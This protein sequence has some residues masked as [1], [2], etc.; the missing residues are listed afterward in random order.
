MKW[1][2]EGLV[3]TETFLPF[4]DS[5]KA[6][7]I[8]LGK[9]GY[10]I[11]SIEF[12]PYPSTGIET[13]AFA[14][15]LRK[16]RESIGSVSL[17]DAIYLEQISTLLPTYSLTESFDDQTV[18]GKW[19]TG[20]V[21][22]SVNSYRRFSALMSWLDKPTIA[23]I[24][25]AAGYSIQ[26]EHSSKDGMAITSFGRDAQNNESRLAA[27]AFSLPGRPY[28]EDFFNEHVLE[29][30]AHEDAYRRMGI[31]F[32]SAIVLHGPPG[33]GKTFAVD[34]LV[35]F[36]DWP[37]YSID[38]GSIGSPFI[39]D[40][41]KKISEVF[42]NAIDNAPSVIIIDEMEAFLTDRNSAQGASTY[43]IEEVAEFLRRIPEA[44]KNRVLI[45]AMTNMI[46][47]IDPAILR[48][49]RFDHII[50][51][52]MP[53]VEEVTLLLTS[54]LSKIPTSADVDV[55]NAA[56]SLQGRPISDVAFVVKEAARMAVKNEKSSVD[57]EILSEVISQLQP[58]KDSSRKIGF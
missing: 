54:L 20:G 21:C 39:H 38:S 15:A 33:C 4:S 12:G 28:L 45:I 41:G 53:T 16:S 35:D 43:H 52:N 56:D 48:R 13:Q 5:N 27:G 23:S 34:K 1:E 50:E 32:P 6:Y 22:I 8:F 49:G 31:E 19:L 17:H 36:L 58:V 40:T 2:N 42:D 11:S 14:I 37:S 24:V 57:R 10:L 3:P 26:K 25:S 44:P 30:L 9:T 51:V 7:Y 46:D 29:I 55:Q 47:S 18:L